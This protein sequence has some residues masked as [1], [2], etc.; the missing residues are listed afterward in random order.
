[1]IEVLMLTGIAMVGGVFVTP[2]D[3][4]AHE[5]DDA[6]VGQGDD[7]ALTQQP[8]GQSALDVAEALLAEARA[9][10]DMPLADAETDHLGDMMRIE[11]FDPA[12]DAVE[13][14]YAED[15]PATLDDISVRY[16]AEAGG[17]VLSLAGEEMV[18][19]RNVFPDD[20]TSENVTLTAEG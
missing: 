4:D 3:M 14:M 8:G 7:I 16:D 6:M 9:M 20:L 18:F 10:E 12:Q 13:L 19:L 15:T 11:A 17:S 5:A 2:D 1:M